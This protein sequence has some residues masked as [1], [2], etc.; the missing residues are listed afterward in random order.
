M[1]KSLIVVT[2]ATGYIGSQLVFALLSKYSEKFTVRV[3]ARK[4]SDC[5]FLEG[6]PVEIVYADLL[7]TLALTDAFKGADTVFHCAGFISYTRNFRNALYDINVLGTRNVV[8]ASLFNGVR[9]LVVTSSIAAIGATE[10]GAPASESTSF[11]EWQRRNGYMEAKHLAELEALRGVAEGLDVVMVNP[12]VVIGTD[13]RNPASVSSSNDVL[14]L[15]YQGKLPLY[16]SGSTGFVDVRDV[17]D[18]HIA[19]WETGR[20]GERYIIVGYNLLFRDLFDRIGTLAGSSIRHTYMVP[21]SMGILAGFGGELWSML[22][23]RPSVISFE[24]IRI[25]SRM[26]A[27]SNTR[28]LEELSL[29]YRELSETLNTIII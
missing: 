25:S 10:D 11:Q 24:S 29:S 13:R 19:A 4:S 20:S 18:A 2:G 14:R 22:S 12:G 7:N 23:N 3:I 16:P 15:I 5:S 8:N 28:S 1:L 9:K 6:L 26:L 21:Q 27:Y 17:A